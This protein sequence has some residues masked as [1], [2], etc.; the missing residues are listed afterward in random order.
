MSDE[1]TITDRG[2][3]HMPAIAG[4]YGGSIHAYES[5]AASAPHLWVSATDEDDSTAIIHLTL[6]QALRLAEQ[7]R[8]LA[9]HHYQLAER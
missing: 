5:S 3:K 1:P 8:Y 9:E 7:I 4:T 6:D 2:F